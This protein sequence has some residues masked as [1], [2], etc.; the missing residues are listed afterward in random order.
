MR[1]CIGCRERGRRADLVR[2][3]ARGERVVVDERASAPGRGAWLHCRSACLEQAV[4]RRAI[5][6]A[7]RMQ[8]P[9]DDHAVWTWFGAIER[10]EHRVE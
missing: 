9:I 5:G 8:G 2:L 10:A 6:R 3:I 1:T 7:L 4:R